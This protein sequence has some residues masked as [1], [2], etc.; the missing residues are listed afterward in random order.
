[1]THANS[2]HSPFSPLQFVQFQL[3]RSRRVLCFRMDLMK[4]ECPTHH[5]Q[6]AMRPGWASLAVAARDTP[7]HPPPPDAAL[8]SRA[9]WIE[10][11]GELMTTMMTRWPHLMLL[12]L[13]S[14]SPGKLKIVSVFE[15]MGKKSEN[16]LA[17]LIGLVLLDR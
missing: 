14:A 13:P 4:I 15:V 10:Q 2:S 12:A 5:Q 9:V 17:L 16:Y 11:V 6:S 7:V 8:S 3:N 1:M